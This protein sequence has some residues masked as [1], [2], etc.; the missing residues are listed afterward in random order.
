MNLDQLQAKLIVAA[1]TQAPSTA[2]PYAF[3]RRLTARLKSLAVGDFWALWG[4]ALWRAVAPCVAIALLLAAWSLFS[5]PGRPAGGDLSQDF[6]NTVLA[7]TDLDQPA[8]DSVQ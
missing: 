2:V 8:V 6:E 4:P 3:E 7:A 1:R 5:P